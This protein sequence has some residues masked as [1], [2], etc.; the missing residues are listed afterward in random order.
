MKTK[1]PTKLF[2]FFEKQQTGNNWIVY[3]LTCCTFC[4]GKHAPYNVCVA[5]SYPPKKS[6]QC[7]P[8]SIVFFWRAKKGIAEPKIKDASLPFVNEIKEKYGFWAL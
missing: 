1:E 7:V 5:F 2:L 4:P 8:L 6:K 3:F